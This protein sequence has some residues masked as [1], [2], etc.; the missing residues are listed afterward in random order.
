M[1]DIT[2]DH[3]RMDSQSESRLL[4]AYIQ[5]PEKIAYY[6]KGL[7]KMQQA[8]IFGFKWHWSWWAFFFGWAFLLY[9]KA[10]LPALGAFI[11]PIFLSLIPVIGLLIAMILVGGS[12]SYFILKRYH[13]LKTTL[14]GSEE[15]AIQAMY[16]FGGFHTWVIWVAAV[17]YA[18]IGLSFL[19][20]LAV[21]GAMSSSGYYGY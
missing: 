19:A 7:Q 12:S 15:E 14:Q 10:Y 5:K 6:Q 2:A 3:Q 4:E 11:L 1:S 20:G 21:I 18:L 17:V 16:S 9:R 13:D 8:G